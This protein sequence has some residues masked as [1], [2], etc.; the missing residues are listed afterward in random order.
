MERYRENFYLLCDQILEDYAINQ[1]HI[2]LPT[3]QEVFPYMQSDVTYE[4]DIIKIHIPDYLPRSQKVD[5]EIAN[6]WIE[7]IITS[8]YS[9]PKIPHWGKV[10][11]YMVVSAPGGESWDID[12]RSINLIINAI[13]HSRIIK[14]DNISHL[15]FGA[16]GVSDENHYTDIYIF[17]YYLM[18]EKLP[19]ISKFTCE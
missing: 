16:E 8:I 14:D 12:N 11:V 17:N 19:F 1:S 5:K 2:D 13:K 9:I 6:K 3:K 10:F 7:N 4:N 18:A 15:A